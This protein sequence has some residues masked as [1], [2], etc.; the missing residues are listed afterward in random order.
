MKIYELLNSKDTVIWISETSIGIIL[1]T[2][3]KKQ[4]HAQNIHYETLYN[5]L[6]IISENFAVLKG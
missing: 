6:R 1:K 5:N 2:K 4:N 3:T